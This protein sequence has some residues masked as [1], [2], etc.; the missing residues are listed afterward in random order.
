VRDS[1]APTWIA[2]AD[3]VGADP[4]GRVDLTKLLAALHDQGRRYVLLEGGPILA[5]AFWG[6]GLVDRVVAYLAPALLGA[7]PHA[8]SEAGVATIDAAIRLDITDVATVGEDIRVTAVP[9][10]RA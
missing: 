6:A 1:S 5:G 8:L 2:T 3:E 7:G 10:R 9:R 4:D